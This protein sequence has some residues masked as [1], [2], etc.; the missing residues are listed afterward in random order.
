ME[1]GGHETSE[2]PRSR[3]FVGG[4]KRDVTW[5]ILEEHFKEY[6]TLKDCFVCYNKDSGLSRRFGFVEFEDPSAALRALQDEH[7]ILDQKAD[8]SVA[9]ERNLDNDS[10]KIFV[11]GLPR[12][13]TQK[14]LR[15]FFEKFG[16]V[17]D[18]NLVHNRITKASRGFGFVTFESKHS[19][20]AVLRSRFHEFTTG[21]QV[22]VKRANPLASNTTVGSNVGSYELSV[23]PTGLFDYGCYYWYNHY[24][25]NQPYWNMYYPYYQIPA[26]NYYYPEAGIAGDE[27][28]SDEIGIVAA[29]HGTEHDVEVSG[30]D[31]DSF[32][33]KNYLLD[34][35]DE[36]A[37]GS[38]SHTEQNQPNLTKG[39][40]ENGE[41]TNK[42]WIGDHLLL[43]PTVYKLSSVDDSRA[44][45]LTSDDTRYEWL[46]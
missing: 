46:C 34:Q 43:H 19:T 28:V 32:D 16:T 18:S 12:T 10:R 30:V 15:T 4:L 8:V 9:K 42:V 17:T 37:D 1:G 14:E 11:G 13:V 44:T 36:A 40:S 33:M 21:W 22:E 41:T 29:D 45:N 35:E 31:N 38:E 23:D 27:Q 20:D 6:G 3:L 26:T 25:Y 7:F 39:S 5:L 2:L 24:W